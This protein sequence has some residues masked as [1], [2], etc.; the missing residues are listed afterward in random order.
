M[1]KTDQ[2]QTQEPADDFAVEISDLPPERGSHYRLLKLLAFRT[3]LFAAIQKFR[4]VQ[5][6]APSALSSGATRLPTSG[7]ISRVFAVAGL[8]LILGILLVGNIPPLRTRVIGLLEPPTPAVTVSLA[9]ANYFTSASSFSLSQDHPA[10]VPTPS[11]SQ[12][13]MAPL[14][15]SCPKANSL[16]DFNAPLDPP[17]LGDGPVWL[18][19]FSG[20]IAALVHV[21]QAA[22]PEQGWYETVTLFIAQSTTTPI[23]F[24]GG[25]QQA[26]GP[27]AFSSSNSTD[28]SSS[29]T[30]SPNAHFV[31]DG[32]WKTTFMNIYV[33][34]A[35]CYS[36]RAFWQTGSWTLYFAAGS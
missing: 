11:G 16:R 30:I 13:I 12:Q 18:N 27:L 26:E 32:H 4:V 20:P 23:I 3:H 17:G 8:V 19:G 31:T 7:R 5:K 34:T 2:Q 21:Q 29:L 36:L 22:R 35:G 33:P 6:H 10:N 28:T 9:N 14:P 1:D 24:A 15:A 25:G